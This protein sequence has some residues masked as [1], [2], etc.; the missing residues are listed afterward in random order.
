[1]NA[2]IRQGVCEASSELVE[3]LAEAKTF[4]DAAHVVCDE[5]VRF[6]AQQCIVFLHAASGPPVLAVDNAPVGP[7]DLRQLN[8]GATGA[9]Q[10]HPLFTRLRAKL[11]PAWLGP[12]LHVY[13]LPVV[14]P[15][16]WFATVV[17]GSPRSTTRAGERDMT[18]VA[19]Q[20]AEWCVVRGVTRVPELPAESWLPAHQFRMARLAGAGRSNIEIAVELGMSVFAVD[21]QIDEAC[22]RL[23]VLS[24]LQLAY[25]VRQLAPLAGIPLGVSRTSSLMIARDRELASWVP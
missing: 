24:R 25:V 21:S 23:G 14:G 10:V 16:G 9:W 4:V 3:A 11:E 17:F 12:G 13:G 18:D 1:M 7:S 19:N 15:T 5:A 22:A 8:V 20:F 2:G 6:D